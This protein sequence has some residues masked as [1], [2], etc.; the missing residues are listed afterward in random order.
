MDTIYGSAS[1]QELG[2]P[3]VN[4]GTKPNGGFGNM[5]I[6]DITPTVALMQAATGPTFNLHKMIQ[7]I[8]SVVPNSSNG[9]TGGFVLG[10]FRDQQHLDIL[11]GRIYWAD[12]NGNYD[13]TRFT[14]LK[15]NIPSGNSGIRGGPILPYYV[16]HLTSDTIDDI[17]VSAYTDNTD[18]FPPYA[19]HDTAYVVLFRGGQQLYGKDT[20][21]DDTSA[22]L[23]PM[24]P[25]SEA[26]RYYTQADFRG[27]GRDDLIVSDINTNLCY[28]KNDPPFSLQQF[29]QAVTNDTIF[30]GLA[31]SQAC[32]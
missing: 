9:L 19:T 3:V 30:C 1:G 27:V 22:F 31:E 7:Y 23:Y 26:F 2:D 5:L 12:D 21:Y 18:T 32:Q 10:H 24:T 13:S 20:V 17:L 29:A 25:N 8:Q 4:H 6:G 16:T 14:V 11:D 28:Y 15:E